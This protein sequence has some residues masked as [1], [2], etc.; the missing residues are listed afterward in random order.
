MNR[1]IFALS[2]LGLSSLAACN[3]A[4]DIPQGDALAISASASGF[5]SGSATASRV[6]YVYFDA[7][8][9]HCGHLWETMKEFEDRLK[10]V[11]IPVGLLNG[12]S[13]SQGVALLSSPDPVKTM[14]EHEQ[15]LA[16]DKRGMSA[17]MPS[18]EQVRVI[19]RNTRLLRATGADAV[20]FIVMRN[21]AGKL[22]KETG[23]LPAAALRTLFGL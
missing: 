12:A 22:V 16:A 18:A 11:W 4:N 9:P 14:N 3:D 17:P 6:V 23:A 1:R 10:V 13:K 8:C 2:L 20:P 7:Q 21:P 5:V 19:E 15:R